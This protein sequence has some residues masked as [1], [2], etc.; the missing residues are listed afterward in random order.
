MATYYDKDKIKEFLEPEQ[1]Y[2][3]LTEWGGQPTWGQDCI[4]SDTICH[5]PPGEGSHKLYY[6]FGTRLCVCYTGCQETSFDIFELCIKVAKIQRHKKYEL[7]DAMHYIANYFG[8]EGEDA[9]QEQESDTLAD[10]SIFQRYAEVSARQGTVIGRPHLKEYDSSILSHLSYPA[11]ATWEQEG[12]KREV[13]K[14]NK[15]GYY[16]MT[17]QITIP[18]FDIDGRFVGL[19]GRF[20]SEEDAE[21]YGKYRPLVVNH[22]SYKHPL[23]VNLY[24][25]NNSKENIRRV[26]AAIVLEGESF[27]PSL[28]FPVAAG[29]L[30]LAKI[31][32][33]DKP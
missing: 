26:H 25:L 24:N 16:P 3:L 8:L 15:I 30:R 1:I 5:N 12:I 29:G 21:R 2:D 9:P 10:W 6:Y 27:R 17:D 31:N 19:R 23:S 18:H 28:L 14:K 33:F 7:Y 4:I 32:K 20:L 22:I 13:C 11:I